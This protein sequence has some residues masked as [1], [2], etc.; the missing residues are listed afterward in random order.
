MEHR[1]PDNH[2]KKGPA[3]PRQQPEEGEQVTTGTRVC[4]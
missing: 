3:L 1:Q 4:P 2:N